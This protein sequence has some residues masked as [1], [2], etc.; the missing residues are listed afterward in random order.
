MA[1]GATLASLIADVQLE[2]GHSTTTTVGQQFRGHI[3]HRIQ[4]EYERLYRDFSWPHVRLWV[5]MLTVSGMKNYQLPVVDGEQLTLAD[6]REIYVKNGGVYEPLGRGIEIEDYSAMDSD[7]GAFSDPAQ[8]WEP[9]S[10]TLIELWPCPASDGQTIR[11]KALQP[12]KQIA[13]EADICRLDDQLVSLY[14]AGEYLLRQSSKDAP[15]VVA[16]AALYYASLKQRYQTGA[17]RVQ[18]LQDGPHYAP[19]DP[20][21]K[22]FVGVQRAP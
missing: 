21:R 6:V 13:D 7:A 19:N 10:E 17:N 20:R 11:M 9:R 4:R 15:A 12:F 5:D 3:T 18:L 16:R 22:V 2:L 1:T 8:K 14:A